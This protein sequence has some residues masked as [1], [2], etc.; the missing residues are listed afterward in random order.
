MPYTK[1]SYLM[2]AFHDSFS[3]EEFFLQSCKCIIILTYLINKEV[4]IS[5]CINLTR[6]YFAILCL[7]YIKCDQ[8][9]PMK[10]IMIR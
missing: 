7:S 3:F 1:S 9:G 2:V 8:I 5:K 10:N 4:I 6:Y